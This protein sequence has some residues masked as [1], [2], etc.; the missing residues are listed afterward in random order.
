MATKDQK[1]KTEIVKSFIAQVPE[2]KR[3]P[4][5]KV[6]EAVLT[7]LV[8]KGLA[9]TASTNPY[10][11]AAQIRAQPG[12]L[13]LLPL[14]HRIEIADNNDTIKSVDPSDFVYLNSA[15]VV[16]L[17]VELARETA[18]W[19]RQ[20]WPEHP[21][22]LSQTQ[23][24][25]QAYMVPSY[26]IAAGIRLKR[27]KR[28][29]GVDVAPPIGFYWTHKNEPRIV[30]WTR[31]VGGHQRY[32]QYKKGELKVEPVGEVY[33]DSIDMYV[34]SDSTDGVRHKVA[35]DHLP[36]FMPADSRQYSEWARMKSMDTTP[37]ARFRGAM[38]QR[39]AEK[40]ILFS[41]NGVMCFDVIQDLYDKSDGKEIRINP[42]PTF[43][44][45]RDGVY[46]ALQNR[47]LI[48]F[49]HPPNMMEEDRIL[50]ADTMNEDYWNN[51]MHWKRK[52]H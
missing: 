26:L 7:E 46:D 38:H 23:L 32:L 48:G 36:I 39:R 28:K 49:H 45:G 50:G 13:V 20:T 17:A 4:P 21:E 14:E 24:F 29:A 12:K 15:P 47:T 8:K 16:R 1:R 9:F 31:A 2:W 30:T 52:M 33:G 43:K 22:R 37:D 3:N 5:E 42:F 35:W 27:E 6:S 11:A 19:Y 44:K 18:G 25:Q 51:M 34:H 41:R 10:E 40:G